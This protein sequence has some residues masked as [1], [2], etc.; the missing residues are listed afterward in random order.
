M[1]L[2]EQ[3]YRC[4]CGWYQI[5]LKEETETKRSN[6]LKAEIKKAN[7]QKTRAHHKSDSCVN[8]FAGTMRK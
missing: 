6:S 3:L 8:Y 2:Q 1:L 4:V 5:I 7:N